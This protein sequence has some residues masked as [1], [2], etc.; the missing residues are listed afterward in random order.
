MDSQGTNY[1]A[2]AN[3]P[4]PFTDPSQPESLTWM[5]LSSPSRQS[6]LRVIGLTCC[7]HFLPL[8]LQQPTYISAGLLTHTLSPYTSCPLFLQGTE[9][10]SCPAP[11]DTHTLKPATAQAYRTVGRHNTHEILSPAC[12]YLPPLPHSSAASSGLRLPSPASSEV[13]ASSLHQTRKPPPPTAT[14]PVPD[15]IRSD[16]CHENSPSAELTFFPPAYESPLTL[17]GS[18]FDLTSVWKAASPPTLV[19]NSF[20]YCTAFKVQPPDWQPWRLK[21]F[22]SLCEIRSSSDKPSHIRT[23]APAIVWHPLKLTKVG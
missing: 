10:S 23:G 15:H 13:Q 9:A 8:A 1:S 16:L 3:K 2:Y 12:S 19:P 20:G 11:P 6:I 22:P 7:P 14:L 17:P 21:G 4:N 5:L 18:S